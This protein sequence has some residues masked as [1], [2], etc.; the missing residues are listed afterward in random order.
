[1][2][3]QVLDDIH[4]VPFAIPKNND[5][6]YEGLVN[7]LSTQDIHAMGG[8]EPLK[9]ISHMMANAFLATANSITAYNL[10]I[11]ERIVGYVDLVAANVDGRHAYQSHFDDLRLLVQTDNQLLK[12]LNLQVSQLPLSQGH[13]TS[14]QPKIGEPPEFNGTDGKVKF[15]E[16]LNKISLWL[17]HEGVATDKQRIAVAM[18]RL[19]GAA[20]QYMEPWIK[21]LTKGESLGSWDDF[22]NEL[23]VQY[24]QRDE[25]EGAKKELTALFANTDLAHKNFVKYAERFRTLGRITGYEDELLID[26]LNSV[27]E[28]DMRLALIGYKSH[29]QVPKEWGKYLDMLLAIYKEVHPD[30]V[31]GHIFSKEKDLS[32]SMDV[33]TMET[34]NKKK[35][36]FKKSDSKQVNSTEK[37]SK[38]CH[39]CKK[40]FHDT[41]EC[42]YNGKVAETPK[43]SPPMKEEAKKRKE[44]SSGFKKKIRAAT[45]QTSDESD[46]DDQ[47]KPPKAL[48]SKHSANTI[49]TL[50]KEVDDND[51][52]SDPPPPSDKG[53]D[54]RKL[55]EAKDFLRST[56]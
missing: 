55:F 43:E 36:N 45:A 10:A 46:S 27:M 26:K 40:K 21:K 44:A 8:Q 42:R 7:G 23:R 13:G 5:Q 4:A 34:Q 6:W 51:E 49:T 17:V 20:A 3:T 18:G 35:K 32:T 41:E 48:S 37:S 47:E 12:N 53:K 54:K 29:G 19:S 33:D 2:S 22:V 39:I 52:L 25:R 28:K 9:V 56:M 31:Q 50:L 1:M 38:F 15:N 16:W 14:R 24:G 11:A 30:K